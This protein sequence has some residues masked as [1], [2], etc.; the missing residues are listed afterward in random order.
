MNQYIYTHGYLTNRKG[1]TL[2]ALIITIIVMIILA[3]VA[4]AVAVGDGGVINKAQSATDSQKYKTAREQIETQRVYITKGE[5]VG[6]IDLETTFDNINNLGLEEIDNVEKIPD[7]SAIKVTLKNGEVII[8][9]GEPGDSSEVKYYKLSN[10][11]EKMVDG[12]T[13][14]RKKR[15]I[16]CRL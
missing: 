4:I 5:N 8:I 11:F 13:I 15:N 3:G 16:W 12:R 2:V 10:E 6:K 14:V 9:N 1:I 7:G